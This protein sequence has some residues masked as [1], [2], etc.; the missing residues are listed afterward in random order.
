MPWD[1]DGSFRLRLSFQHFPTRNYA[2]FYQTVQKYSGV[3]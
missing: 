1:G 3:S 2:S